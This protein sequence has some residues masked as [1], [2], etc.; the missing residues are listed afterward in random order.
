MENSGQPYRKDG[1]E[2]P[3][4]EANLRKEGKLLTSSLNICLEAAWIRGYLFNDD[5]TDI[6]LGVSV[7]FLGQYLL[8]L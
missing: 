7:S 5:V 4:H 6:L 3:M 2:L 8:S 1:G